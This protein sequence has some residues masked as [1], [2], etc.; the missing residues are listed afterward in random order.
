[1]KI[2]Q[3]NFKQIL[4]E[5]IQLLLFEE[6]NVGMLQEELHGTI[7][8]EEGTWGK[9]SKR[10]FQKQIQDYGATPELDFAAD[11]IQKLGQ[12]QEEMAN[13]I[14]DSKASL[15]ELRSF[16]KKIDGWIET[17]AAKFKK[18]D[19]S[20]EPLSEALLKYKDGEA[21]RIIKKLN[22]ITKFEKPDGVFEIRPEAALEKLKQMND[23]DDEYK[24]NILTRFKHFKDFFKEPKEGYPHERIFFSKWNDEIKFYTNKSEAEQAATNREKAGDNEKEKKDFINSLLDITSSSDLPAEEKKDVEQAVNQAIPVFKDKNFSTE[25]QFAWAALTDFSIKVSNINKSVK[26]FEKE[27]ENLKNAILDR[28]I[29]NPKIASPGKT[30]EEQ[31][32]RIISE[33]LTK[34]EVRDIAKEESE[35]AISRMFKKELEDELVKLFKKR[36][37]TKE[38]IAAISRDMIKKLYR[39]LAF[40]YPQIL[41]RIRL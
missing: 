16:L 36:G 13:K 3:S 40:N 5:E 27:L 31:L 24:K 15:Q 9:L 39:E 33:E 30:L 11:F 2:T 18:F 29:E 14:I 12:F 21:N 22:L 8:K 23:L 25:V 6:G 20:K 26:K 41:D 37:D 4:L 38:E 35:K 7:L 17:N 32:R 34:A 1:M 10:F 28:P 19:K